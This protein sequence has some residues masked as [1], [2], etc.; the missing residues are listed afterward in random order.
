MLSEEDILFILDKL[1][2]YLLENSNNVN[3]STNVR[4]RYLKCLLADLYIRLNLLVPIKP[5]EM[6]E[7]LL[8]NFIEGS[9]SSLVYN[10][11]NIPI[12]KSVVNSVVSANGKVYDNDSAFE[13]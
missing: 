4:K 3:A 9:N 7:L 11:V 2:T 12:P 6:I 8:P 13:K 1:E 5:S 10:D